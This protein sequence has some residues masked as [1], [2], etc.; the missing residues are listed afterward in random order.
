M[1]SRWMKAL[2]TMWLVSSNF[3]ES[4]TND[5]AT[6]T[7]GIED[8]D[9]KATTRTDNNHGP[10]PAMATL[11]IKSFHSVEFMGMRLVHDSWSMNQADTHC[12]CNGGLVWSMLTLAPVVHTQLFTYSTGKRIEAGTYTHTSDVRE[13]ERGWLCAGAIELRTA[14][15]EFV[16]FIVGVFGR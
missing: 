13:V 5:K 9:S 16:K 2:C 1:P 10:T 6:D 8:T 14:R 12:K 7:Q 3:L 15:T 4:W 11:D